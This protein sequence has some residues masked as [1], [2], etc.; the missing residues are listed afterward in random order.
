MDPNENEDQVVDFEYEI[1][2]IDDE[3]AHDLETLAQFGY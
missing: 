2:E 1:E 3:T